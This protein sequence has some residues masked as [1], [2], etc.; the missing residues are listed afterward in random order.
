[1]KHDYSVPVDVFGVNVRNL[2]VAEAPPCEEEYRMSEELWRPGR[3]DVMA[4]HWHLVREIAA[5]LRWGLQVTPSLSTYLPF[6][7]AVN[8]LV[9]ACNGDPADGP[10]PDGETGDPVGDTADTATD[11]EPRTFVGG[12]SDAA[13]NAV[14]LP[15]DVDGD[16]VPDVVIGA[17]YGNRVC[18][19]SGRG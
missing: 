19:F 11:A 6:C 2:D 10:A 8:L 13:G 15:G 16:D 3:R 4:R 1:M 17:Y 12:P 14:A 9:S 18:I 7:F 5:A